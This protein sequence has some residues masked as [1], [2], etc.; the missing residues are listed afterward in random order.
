M[1][2]VLALSA[3][4]GHAHRCCGAAGAHTRTY[5]YGDKC[6]RCFKFV[7]YTLAE[8]EEQPTADRALKPQ[9]KEGVADGQGAGMA[10]QGWECLSA[11]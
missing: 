9:Q 3:I 11:L 5:Y 7:R 10:D 8:T 2:H 1:L 6:L 4:L